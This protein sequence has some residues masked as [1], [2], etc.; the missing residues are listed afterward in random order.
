MFKGGLFLAHSW[1][2]TL[3]RLAGSFRHTSDKVEAD[4]VSM[5]SAIVKQFSTAHCFQPPPPS[6]G[7]SVV[8]V[9]GLGGLGWDKPFGVCRSASPLSCGS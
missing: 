2:Q 9:G 8:G 3:I 7:P 4:S 1:E 5:N 6:C